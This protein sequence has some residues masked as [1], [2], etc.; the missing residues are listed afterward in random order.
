MVARQHQSL[1]YSEWTPFWP[2][3]MGLLSRI[4]VVQA[5]GSMLNCPESVD[6]GSTLQEDPNRLP[7]GLDE[8]PPYGQL[9]INLHDYHNWVANISRS[10]E[11]LAT[12]SENSI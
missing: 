10:R 2:E 4:T 7:I 6:L 9:L 12:A 5:R 8:Q 3:A 1:R 11:N